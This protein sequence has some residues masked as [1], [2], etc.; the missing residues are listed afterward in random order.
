MKQITLRVGGMHCG[1]CV[2][3]V[4]QALEAVPGVHVDAV[5]IGAATVTIDERVAGVGVLIDAVYEAGY[6]AEEGAG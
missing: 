5:R 3:S 2:A 4:Q 6:E 1:G